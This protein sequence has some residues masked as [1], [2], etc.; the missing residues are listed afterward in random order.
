MAQLGEKVEFAETAVVPI[1]AGVAVARQIQRVFHAAARQAENV[2]HGVAV[3]VHRAGSEG[4]A[5][6]EVEIHHAVEQ[7][8]AA[9]DALGEGAGFFAGGD[10]AAAYAAGGVQ[11]A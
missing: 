6:G 3:L 11:T 10:K 9:V 5:I 8:L 4:G 7:A 2:G 1:R